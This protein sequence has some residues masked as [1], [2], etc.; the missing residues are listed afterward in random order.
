M[1][2]DDWRI[3]YERSIFET[4]MGVSVERGEW[5]YYRRFVRFLYKLLNGKDLEP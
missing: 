1:N 5:S 3:A 4:I 2:D